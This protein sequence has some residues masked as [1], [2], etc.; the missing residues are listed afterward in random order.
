MDQVGICN[1][2]LG[3]IGAAPINKIND[4]SKASTLCGVFWDGAVREVLRGHP[5]NFAIRRAQLPALAEPPAFGYSGAF[6][7]PTD[8][9][10]TLEVIGQ[11]DYRHEGGVI[12]A[13]AASLRL[14]Y[15]AVVS[16]VDRF[17]AL[18]TAALAANLSF[19]LAYP[20][21]QSSA[22]Q[23]AQ[24]KLYTQ[25][26]AQARSVDAQEDPS[27]DFFEESSLIT[28]RGIAS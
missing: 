3:L 5:W 1:T 9:L 16:D 11:D 27:E 6:R 15:I 22:Q 12:L 10:R 14:K 19:K 25:Q 26:L 28:A 20:L 23:D 24:W 13:N 2:A 7:L 8:W 17:D 4:G 21:T 18:F